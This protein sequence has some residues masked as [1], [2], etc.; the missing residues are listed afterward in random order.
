M[1]PEICVQ[2]WCIPCMLFISV[3]FITLT[4]WKTSSIWFYEYR[5]FLINARAFILFTWL[6]GEA[7]VYSRQAFI[8]SDMILRGKWKLLF[9][10]NSHQKMITYVWNERN[11]LCTMKVEWTSSMKGIVTHDTV[12]RLNSHILICLY[13]LEIFERQ[14]LISR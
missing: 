9:R 3:V 7:G 14:R 8:F 12:Y 10:T 11:E 1:A 4:P 13:L 2:S 6:S 5:I